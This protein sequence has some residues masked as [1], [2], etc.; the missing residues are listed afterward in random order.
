MISKNLSSFPVMMSASSLSLLS[1]NSAYSGFN[2]ISCFISIGSGSLR[3]NFI[4]SM[5][6]TPIL[7][8]TTFRK[9]WL[10]LF[11]FI[12]SFDFEYIDGFYIRAAENGCP[13]FLSRLGNLSAVPQ[14]IYVWKCHMHDHGADFSSV[15]IKIPGISRTVSPVA[16]AF[17]Q[18]VN[19]GNLDFRS[20]SH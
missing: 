6:S 20:S 3:M 14:D 17:S 12:D 15:L 11:L 19:T 8:Y 16:G 13:F 4:C 18:S 9:D 2:G 5:M 1:F 10:V 7:T